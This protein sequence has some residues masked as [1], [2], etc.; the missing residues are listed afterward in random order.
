MEYFVIFLMIIDYI[1]NL[2]FQTE[3]DYKSANVISYRCKI[4]RTD[5]SHFI[6]KQRSINEQ[7][8]LFNH[9]LSIQLIVS[10]VKIDL[11]DQFY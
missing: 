8:S 5:L 3:L 7:I 2:N 9:Q 4:L 10:R 6:H 1:K 11:K